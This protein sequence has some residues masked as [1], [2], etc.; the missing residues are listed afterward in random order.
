M[1]SSPLLF[2]SVPFTTD[3]ERVRQLC[4]Q[5]EA[6]FASQLDA[7][8]RDAQE[9]HALAQAL[10]WPEGLATTHGWL[11]RIYA[12]KGMHH[13]V[14]E[15]SQMALEFYRQFDNSA[16]MAQSHRNLGTAHYHQGRLQVA[17]THYLEALA[18]A[19]RAQDTQGI[20]SAYNNIGL[21]YGAQGDHEKERGYYHQYLHIKEKE[22]DQRSIAIAYIN[23]ASSYFFQADYQS[24]HYY[25]L[26]SLESAE[27][28]PSDYYVCLN[29]A[30]L[31][32]TST[33]LG[34]HKYAIDYA[35]RGLVLATQLGAERLK[36]YLDVYG[37]KALLCQGRYDEALSHLQEGLAGA[38]K[39]GESQAQLDALENLVEWHSNR[40]YHAEALLYY[41]DYVKLKETIFNDDKSRHI[42][43][44]QARFEGE[45]KERE[46]EIYRLKNVELVAKNELIEKANAELAAAVAHLERLHQE[47]DEL[48]NILAHDLR[49]PLTR[50]QLDV[51]LLLL[52]QTSQNPKNQ[53]QRLQV[54]KET[55]RQ[56]VLIMNRILQTSQVEAGTMSLDVHP[57]P[58]VPLVKAIVTYHQAQADQKQQTI[59]FTSA[60]T[61]AFI[62]AD[63]QSCEQVL[64]NLLSNAV[65]FSPPGRRI[66]VRI[67]ADAAF[68][69]LTV[70]DEG[71][72]L[73]EA[74]QQA[75]FHKFARLS[76]QPTGGESS[77]GFGLFIVKKLVERMRGRVWVESRGRNQGTTFGIA[78][79][80]HPGTA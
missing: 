9:A 23:I 2:T 12:Q 40:C 57:F 7:A 3:Q 16:G 37:G 27:K 18:L 73:T 64:D 11:G 70:Q 61:E 20:A 76:T 75:A 43:E 80:R 49:N 14:L 52:Q 45:Q 33:Q 62:V 32:R 63:S 77:V 19:E 69:F 55:A 60:L 47:K 34:E 5:V 78:L 10:A 35:E 39:I 25:S 17:L 56:V 15:H 30:N 1:S 4:V 38:N 21:I 58:L 72:G 42:A 71:P 50:I 53:V 36:A 41:R 26:L 13:L 44:M 24:A 54:M 31:C 8:F 79:P 46:A 29:Y 6:L 48:L 51:D 22:G 68:V 65:K 59:S 66:E 28:I 74:E 67:T